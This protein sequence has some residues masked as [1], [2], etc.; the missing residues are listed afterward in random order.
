M[1]KEDLW[2]DDLQIN[3]IDVIIDPKTNVRMTWMIAECSVVC[4]I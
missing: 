4:H 1:E 2:P 3:D